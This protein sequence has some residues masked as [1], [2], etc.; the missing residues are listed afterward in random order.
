MGTLDSTTHSFNCQF[1]KISEL[2]KILDKGSTW[3]GS[4]WQKGP[5]LKHFDVIWKGGNKIEPEILSATC[6]Q[7]GTSISPT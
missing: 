7:C 6:K 2:I 1:C 5:E 3:G 4:H